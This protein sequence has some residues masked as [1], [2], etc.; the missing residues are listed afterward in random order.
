MTD[1]QQL[2]TDFKRMDERSKKLI[3]TLAAKLAKRYAQLPAPALRLVVGQ[4]IK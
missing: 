3:V 2:V 1:E 4:L